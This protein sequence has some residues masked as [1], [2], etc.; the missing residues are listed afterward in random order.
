MKRL[1]V[2]T[3]IVICS[4]VAVAHAETPQEKRKEIEKM[5]RLTGMEK[6]TTQ[7]MGQMIGTLKKQ[8]PDT[9]QDFWNRF[10]R[11]LDPRELI[12]KIIPIYGKYY[13]M[14]DLKAINAFYESPAGKKVLETM[15]QVMQES[16]QIGQ[17][18]GE[19]IGKEAAAEAQQ[20]QQQQQQQPIR[21]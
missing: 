21:R 18:W 15:P 17:A 4:C 8:F 11:K 2:I 10:Q 6:L 20:Q 19:R 1:F 3:L 5:L 13:T 9:S 7:I 14:E 16:M 12:E